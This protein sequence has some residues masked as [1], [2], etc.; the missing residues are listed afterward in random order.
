MGRDWGGA[1][2][3]SRPEQGKGDTHE[4]GGWPFGV[5]ESKWGEEGIWVGT[6]KQGV[7]AEWSEEMSMWEWAWMG[8]EGYLH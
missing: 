5:S 1:T 3:G 2:G 8:G 7:P 6:A 4:G